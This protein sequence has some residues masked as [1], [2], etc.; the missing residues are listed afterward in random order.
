[1]NELALFAG[2]G[3]GLLGSKLL[4]HR[5]V[6][7][8]EYDGYCQ[9]VL[10]ARV[11]DGL[12]D[13]APLF[14]DIRRFIADGWADRYR[15]LVDI[16]SAGFPCQPFSGAGKELGADDPRNMWPETAEVLE[17]VRPRVALLENVPRLL[18]SG[19]F[20]RV[21]ADLA[22]IGF[23][24]EWGVL[25]A[26]DVGAPHRRKRLWVVAHRERQRLEGHAGDGAGVDRQGRLEEIEDRPVGS[27]CVPG[28]V[29][30]A[31]R[32]QL[33]LQW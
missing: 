21:L 9:E 33:P 24:A 15:G 30:D 28:G 19:Y 3:G 18:S 22:A 29:P 6:G 5:I 13:A 26:A 1:M 10:K 4:G 31:E 8:V 27:S 20:G 7:Y 17:R 14:G 2:A 25:G 12:L 23:D 32:D 16:V 11:R